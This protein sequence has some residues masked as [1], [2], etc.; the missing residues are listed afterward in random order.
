M[1]TKVL[2]NIFEVKVRMVNQTEKLVPDKSVKKA[3]RIQGRKYLDTRHS[4]LDWKGMA[5]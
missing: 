5:L 2:N 3:Q 1:N 4:H